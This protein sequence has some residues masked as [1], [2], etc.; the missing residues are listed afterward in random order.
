MCKPLLDVGAGVHL[1]IKLSELFN[2]DEELR[3]ARDGIYSPKSFKPLQ[4]P[5]FI[6]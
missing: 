4:I 2:A 1:F 5:D 6:E 3:L